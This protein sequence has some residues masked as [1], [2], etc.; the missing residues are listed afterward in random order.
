MRLPSLALAAALA[1]LAGCAPD[2]DPASEVTKLRVLAVRAE[3]PEL[4]PPPAAGAP[5]A[6]DAAAL[7][8]LVAHPAFVLDGARRVTVV[9]LACTPDAGDPRP[10]ACASLESLD[11]PRALLPEA[12][13]A[14]ACAD[15]GR[16]RVGAITVAGVEACGRSG[17]APVEVRRDPG[18]PSSLVALPG[19]AYRL[20]GD[21][22]LGA[23]PA[24][25][26]ART[27]GL[28]IVTLALALDVHPDHLAPGE[29]VADACAALAA[30]G[31]RFAEAWDVSPHVATLKRLRVRGPDA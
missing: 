17:C 13:L 27:L 9:H 31:A 15:P 10:S 11:D 1:T 24:G 19:P 30:F 14:L 5:I 6:P 26:P 29:Q 2:F 12:D 20:P 8:A 7:G 23:L 16:G 25:A 21:L 28:E 22:G 18:D 3:P 4:A